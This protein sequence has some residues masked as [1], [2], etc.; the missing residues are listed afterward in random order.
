[1]RSEPSDEALMAD[2]QRGREEAFHEL[3]LRLRGRLVRFLRRLGCEEATAQDLAQEALLRLWL[4]RSSY[5]ASRPVRP[6]VLAIAHNVWADHQSTRRTGAVPLASLSRGAERLLRAH[7]VADATPEALLLEGY[8]RFRIERAVRALPE[9]E[10]L[11]FVLAHYEQLAYREVAQVLGIAEGTVKSR[12]F[13]A[14]RALR[15]ALPD[16]DPGAPG[17]REEQR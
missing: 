6:Y 12:M 4:R 7:A 11:V 9:P 14:V 17:H 8:R 5:Q 15:A 10:R 16:L 3:A 2:A 13:R 1:M